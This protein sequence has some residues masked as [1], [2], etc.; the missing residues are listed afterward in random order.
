MRPR[1]ESLEMVLNAIR[2]STIARASA[3]G[4]EDSGAASM[5][6]GLGV[7]SAMLAQAGRSASHAGH[8]A[9]ITHRTVAKGCQ[10][11]L[12]DRPPVHRHGPFHRLEFDDDRP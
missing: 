3:L 12:V 5:E 11:L 10:R 8:D 4:V 9:A 2:R 7:Q 6:R 1:F